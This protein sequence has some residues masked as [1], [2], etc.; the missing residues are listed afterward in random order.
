MQRNGIYDCITG[1]GVQ[2]SSGIIAVSEVMSD[3]RASWK[4]H[5]FVSLAVSHR[6]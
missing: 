6:K 3:T 5:E 1:G 4:P 2:F